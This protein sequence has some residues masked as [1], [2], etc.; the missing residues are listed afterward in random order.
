MVTNRGGYD[1]G[2]QPL[3][4]LFTLRPDLLPNCYTIDQQQPQAHHQMCVQ[5]HRA[6]QSFS[7]ASSSTLAARC[8]GLLT[9]RWVASLILHTPSPSHN[10]PGLFPIINPLLHGSQCS[11]SLTELGQIH[12]FFQMVRGLLGENPQHGGSLEGNM[13]ATP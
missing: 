3:L 13:E 6:S 11:A 9:A 2:S 10:G 4:P 1:S 5:S 12:S 8:A 7:W